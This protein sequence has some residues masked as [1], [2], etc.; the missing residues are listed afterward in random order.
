MCLV[1]H[2]QKDA[3]LED[4]MLHCGKSGQKNPSSYKTLLAGE[5]RNLRKSHKGGIPLPGWADMQ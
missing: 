4:D 2:S 5:K 3:S 1:G